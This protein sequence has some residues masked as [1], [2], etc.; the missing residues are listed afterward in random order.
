M[1][2]TPPH[3]RGSSFCALLALLTITIGPHPP[4]AVRAEDA[5]TDAGDE[6]PPNADNL[7]GNPNQLC[8]PFSCSKPYVPVAKWPLGITSTGCQ[9]GSG[10]SMMS[11]G[12]SNYKHIEHCCHA[13]NACYQ[14]CGSNKQACDAEMKKC[15]EKGCEELPDAGDALDDMTEE[16][17]KKEQDE[18]NKTKSIVDL[19]ANMGGCNEYDAH[20]RRNC[21]CVD[22]AKV[23]DKMERVL[24]NFYK[25]FQPDGMEKGKIAIAFISLFSFNVERDNEMRS[26][27]NNNLSVKGLLEKAKGKRSVFNKIL[28][29]LVKKYPDAIKKKVVEVPDPLKMDL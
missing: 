29:G 23:E 26:I 6:P 12:G 21:E 25:K 3:R 28:N 14:L 5:K 7:F 17:V 15:M 20:Q 27:T 2:T 11:M 8:R 9:M 1:A 22:K 18:C 4:L 10:I 16:E 13:K 19:L 24:R